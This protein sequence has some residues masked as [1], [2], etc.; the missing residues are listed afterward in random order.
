MCSTTHS[1]TLFQLPVRSQTWWKATHPS[2]L[3]HLTND[4]RTIKG[5]TIEL[6]DLDGN[7]ECCF[8]SHFATISVVVC[9]TSNPDAVALGEEVDG[10]NYFE[11]HCIEAAGSCGAACDAVSVPSPLCPVHLNGTM[12][13]DQIFPKSCKPVV[14]EVEST[15]INS[16]EIVSVNGTTNWNCTCANYNEHI[17]PASLAN[18]NRGFDLPFFGPVEY[19]EWSWMDRLIMVLEVICSNAAV[20][21]WLPSVGRPGPERPDN[22]SEVPSDQLVTR[23]GDPKELFVLS[24]YFCGENKVMVVANIFFTL[25]NMSRLTIVQDEGN[26]AGREL[27]VNELVKLLALEPHGSKFVDD[28]C[29]GILLLVQEVARGEEDNPT[30]KEE[31]LKLLDKDRDKV[32]ELIVDLGEKHDLDTVNVERLQLAFKYMELNNK[33]QNPATWARI[34]AFA[35][36]DRRAELLDHIQAQIR[37]NQDLPIF[38][39]DRNSKG[40]ID[41]VHDGNYHEELMYFRQI[42]NVNDMK[43]DER[44]NKDS[45][46]EHK[47]NNFSGKKITLFYSARANRTKAIPKEHRNEEKKSGKQEGEFAYFDLEE[48][49]TVRL[50]E[51][52]SSILLHSSFALSRYIFFRSKSFRRKMKC[53]PRTSRFLE[54]LKNAKNTI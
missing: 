23:G 11:G 4:V 13:M 19:A 17:E 6:C 16:T 14:P 33:F 50:S 49:R 44:N 18:S 24:S 15:S 28:F 52:A 40:V 21:A 37:R 48:V 31:M 10:T 26:M 8:G 5:Q 54:H 7:K 32:E 9:L 12:R 1:T 20:L 53:R 46:I 27:L 25:R 22:L 43:V 3:E 41:E 2:T 34:L 51:C 30:F 45:V 42:F 29:E 36:T 47:I 35:Q 39:R 38:G